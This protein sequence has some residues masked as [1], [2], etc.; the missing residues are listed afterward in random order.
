[1]PWIPYINDNMLK[2]LAILCAGIQLIAVDEAHC[3]SQW[4]HDFRVAYQ[5]LGVLRD[6]LPAT[7]ILALTATATPPVRKDICTTLKLNNPLETTTDFDRYVFL[8]VEGNMLVNNNVTAPYLVISFR[9]N[10]Y[11]EVRTKSNFIMA[12]LKPIMQITMTDS[13]FASIF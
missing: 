7:P 10:L 12:D 13:R 11:L 9:P 1:M 8:H 6:W 3:V 2:S 5:S 4:G